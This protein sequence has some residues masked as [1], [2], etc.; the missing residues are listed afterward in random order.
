MISIN[1]KIGEMV[2]SD[3]RSASVFK[4]FGID[5]CCGGGVTIDAICEKKGINREDLLNELMALENET[6]DTIDAYN[7]WE[8]SRLVDYI[9]EK[10]HKYTTRTLADL[11]QYLN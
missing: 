7:E 9:I 5:F 2:A 6:N 3:Y 10:H 11:Y 1:N 4:K 8:L